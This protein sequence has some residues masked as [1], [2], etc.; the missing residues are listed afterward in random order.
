MK[1]METEGIDQRR[2]PG[3]HTFEYG[4]AVHPTPHFVFVVARAFCLSTVYETQKRGRGKARTKKNGRHQTKP[5][6][7]AATARTAF[8]K[9]A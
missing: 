5:R 7:T 6:A 4:G 1:R 3:D 8:V 9:A 2:R